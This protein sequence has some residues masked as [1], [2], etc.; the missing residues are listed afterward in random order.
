MRIRE[1][2]DGKTRQKEGLELRPDRSDG[3]EDA[4]GRLQMFA[5][6]NDFVDSSKHLLKAMPLSHQNEVRTFRESLEGPRPAPGIKQRL[7]VQGRDLGSVL[8]NLTS[9]TQ[10]VEELPVVVPVTRWIHPGDHFAPKK[11]NMSL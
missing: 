5:C 4:F 6:S 9:A 2:G 10:Q 7:R 3:R 11:A 8:A 1:L